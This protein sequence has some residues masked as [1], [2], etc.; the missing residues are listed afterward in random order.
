MRQLMLLVRIAPLG[1][2]KSDR[3]RFTKFE[4]QLIKILWRLSVL[5]IPVY[6]LYHSVCMIWAFWTFQEVLKLRP[7]LHYT[8]FI[9]S[10]AIFIPDRWCCLHNAAAI[11]YAAERKS[12]RLEVIWKVIRYVPYHKKP[13][14]NRQSGTLRWKINIVGIFSVY[15][16]HHA[17]RSSTL[18][19]LSYK[20]LLFLANISK[21]NISN[22]DF[23]LSRR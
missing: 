5:P 22:I 2:Q 9:R 20:Q 3:I 1:H 18:F 11:R 12:L 15:M 7:R 8:I 17:T 13:S 4:Q 14:V 16:C 23:F 10:I 21:F 6:L 19:N